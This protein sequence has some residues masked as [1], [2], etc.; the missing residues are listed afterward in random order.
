MN[1]RPG[2]VRLSPFHASALI[3]LLLTVLA[4]G[5]F[6]VAVDATAH[7]P[8][9]R[10]RHEIGMA[11]AALILATCVET[12]AMYFVTARLFQDRWRVSL[13]EWVLPVRGRWAGY[14]AGGLLALLLCALLSG[15]G[16]LAL[17]WGVL[18]MPA[19]EWICSGAGKPRETPRREPAR[20]SE[21][22]EGREPSSRG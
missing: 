8:H 3:A 1:P 18:M 5:I 7:M 15:V 17:V 14:M 19:L 2:W 21:G 6:L 13:P 12:G 16:L 4:W 20:P 9:Q 22:P 11:Y 10:N